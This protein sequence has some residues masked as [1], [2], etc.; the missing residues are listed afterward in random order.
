LS[1]ITE[2]E[3]RVFDQ[4]QQLQR[5]VIYQDSCD[6]WFSVEMYAGVRSFDM[7]DQLHEMQNSQLSISEQ[8]YSLF[9]TYVKFGEAIQEQIDF[10]VIMQK[11]PY[12]TMSS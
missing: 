10:K 2:I 6:L 4:Q 5:K 11:Q 1:E 12:K 9:C 7:T 3:I 8:T